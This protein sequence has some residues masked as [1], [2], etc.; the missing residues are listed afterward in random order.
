MAYITVPKELRERLGETAADQL[1][2]MLNRSEEESRANT[3]DLVEQR[4]R[5]HLAEELGNCEQRLHRE[6]VDLGASLREEMAEMKTSLR[7]E[8]HSTQL[9]TIRWMFAFWVGQMAVL[10]GILLVLVG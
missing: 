2:E 8:I 7:S 10:A 5:R 6:I 1:V 9:A 4:F 3:I